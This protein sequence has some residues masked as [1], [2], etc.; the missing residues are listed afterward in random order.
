M[1]HAM[2]RLSDGMAGTGLAFGTGAPGGGG[3]TLHIHGD[4]VLQ[5]VQDP[6]TFIKELQRLMR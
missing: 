5:G 1:R 2:N 3:M 4:V 6:E